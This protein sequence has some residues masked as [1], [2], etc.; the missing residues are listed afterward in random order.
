MRLR[1]LALALLIAGFAG[2]AASADL[3]EAYE[4]ARKGDPQLAAAEASA[5]S[6]AAGVTQARAALLPQVNGQASL[7]AQKG[8]STSVGTQPDTNSPGQVI[9]GSSTG[10]SDTRTRTVGV[11]LSQSIYDHADYGRLA[12]A[13]ATAAD[14]EADRAAAEQS[15]GVRVATAY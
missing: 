15:L 7:T 14:A 3:L 12:A 6:A 9:F 13:K 10:T 4:L 8:D 11:N 1:P 2:P 5:A